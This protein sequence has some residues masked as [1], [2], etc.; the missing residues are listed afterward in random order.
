MEEEV[1][2]ALEARRQSEE[3]DN[4]Q[5]N[6]KRRRALLKKQ[7]WR[8]SRKKVRGSWLKRRRALLRKLG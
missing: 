3:E 7:G 1:L 4:L 6:P 8:L 2:L 5:I